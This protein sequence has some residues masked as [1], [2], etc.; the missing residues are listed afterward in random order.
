MKLIEFIDSYK[1]SFGNNSELKLTFEMG[2][3]EDGIKR[4]NQVVQRFKEISDYIFKDK[5]VWVLLIIWDANGSNK[6]E[7]LSSGFNINNATSYFHGDLNDGLINKEN[8]Y[9]DA[10]NEAEIL[11]IKYDLYQFECI[12]PLVYSKAGFEL[13][14]DNTA[15]IVS[16]FIT[17][18]N[19]PILLNVYDDRG[20]ELLTH[21]KKVINDVGTKFS[22]Y[23]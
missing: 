21:D 5:E 9:E 3:D 15:G 13:G 19:P 17:F 4:V 8:F 6:K 11:Y 14:I 23:L 22:K 7:L 10:L 1:R 12:F 16:Y 18:E 2:G 20:M